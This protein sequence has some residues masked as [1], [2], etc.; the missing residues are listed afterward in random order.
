MSATPE[1]VRS[2]KGYPKNQ[3]KR[4]IDDVKGKTEGE[5]ES[6]PDPAVLEEIYQLETKLAILK[7]NK[8]RSSGQ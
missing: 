8:A 6:R 1:K 4:N 2:G 3:V 7:D 5:M